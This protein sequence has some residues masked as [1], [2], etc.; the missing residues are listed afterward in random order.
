MNIAIVS[1]GLALAIVVVGFG[2]NYR[3][4]P[5]AIVATPVVWSR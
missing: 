1:A 2:L 4:V 5:R 3:A